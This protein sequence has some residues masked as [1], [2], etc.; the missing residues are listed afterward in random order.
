[1]AI[2][3]A[4]TIS[5]VT[6]GASEISIVSGTTSLQTIATAGVYQLWVDAGAMAKADEF[7]VRAYEKVLSGGTKKV[8]FEQSL[9]GVQSENF[10]APTFILMNGWDMTII[11][12]AGTDRAFSASIRKIV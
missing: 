1:M 6:V 10:V 7:R 9:S 8:F 4:Y 2:T 12:L 3:E 5:A 11:K